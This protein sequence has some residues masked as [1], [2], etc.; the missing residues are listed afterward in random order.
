MPC[1]VEH[2]AL[3]L[4]IERHQFVERSRTANAMSVPSAAA[5]L[6]RSA[7]NPRPSSMLWRNSVD[8]AR[9]DGE[10]FPATPRR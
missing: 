8:T 7:V 2:R 6:R 10:L 1:I 4:P 3:N 9:F 5:V